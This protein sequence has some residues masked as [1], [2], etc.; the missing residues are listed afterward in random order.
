MAATMT[1]TRTRPAPVYVTIAVLTF[2][3]VSATGGGIALTLGAAV[4]PDEW[5]E[6]VPLIDGWLIPGLVLGVGFGLG[7]LLTAY[8]MLRRSRWPWLALVERV[9]AHHWSWIA[10]ILIGAG[11]VVWILLEVLYLP[12]LSWLQFVYGA[13]GIALLALPM[14]TSVQGY[15]SRPVTQRS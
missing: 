9:T 8:G 4:P 6:G 15:L 2:L 12:E 10:T 7:S 14:L 13:V 1:T 5:L 11:Q 3:G